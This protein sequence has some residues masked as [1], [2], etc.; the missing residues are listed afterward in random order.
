MSQFESLRKLLTQHIEYRYHHGKTCR[1]F[2]QKCLSRRNLKKCNFWIFS[3]HLCTKDYLLIL[4]LLICTHDFEFKNTGLFA[5]FLKIRIEHTLF[6]SVW[7]LEKSFVPTQKKIRVI[8]LVPTLKN[9]REHL[10]YWNFWYRL[11][12]WL[13]CGWWLWQYGLLR[14]QAGV[15]Y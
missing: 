9:L 2:L 14:F 10:I 13:G 6:F 15:Q 11:K 1:G 12:G 3:W 8:Q 5:M 7:Q 4:A